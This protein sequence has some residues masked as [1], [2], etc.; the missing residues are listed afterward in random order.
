MRLM[1]QQQQRRQPQV[2]MWESP[3]LTSLSRQHN[4]GDEALSL[5][6]CLCSLLSHAD[7]LAVLISSRRFV[8]SALIKLRRPIGSLILCCCCSS[9]ARSS[10]SSLLRWCR[11]LPH[12][13]LLLSHCC[14][15]RVCTTATL[16]Q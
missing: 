8:F 6:R 9:A 1:G 2:T 11:S 10:S 14:S 15:D 12:L 5:A 16:S 7:L 4:E 3:G 13:L